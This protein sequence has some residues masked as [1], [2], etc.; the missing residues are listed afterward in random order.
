MLQ[1]IEIFLYA[2]SHDMQND[3]VRSEI[4]SMLHIDNDRLQVSSFNK[5]FIPH[6]SRMQEK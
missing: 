5:I 4:M 6:I 3:E 1:N 2:T